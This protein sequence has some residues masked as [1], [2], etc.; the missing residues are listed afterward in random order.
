MRHCP[1][2]L[3]ISS[4]IFLLSVYQFFPATVLSQEPPENLDVAQLGE[5]IEKHLDH[6]CLKNGKYGIQIF[7]LDKRETVYQYQSNQLFI[8]ASNLKLITT[9]VALKHLG[10]DYRFTTG[11][12]T[13]GK[14]EADI[15]HGDLYIKGSGDPKLVTEQM[16]LL[17][18]KLKNLP[19]RKVEGGIIAD[20]SFFDSVR[21]LKTWKKNPGPEAYNAPL[22]ALSFNFNTVKVS[23]M[24]GPDP[25]AKPIVVIDPDTDYIR[26]TNQATTLPAGKRNRLIVNRLSR[27]GFNE[28]VL[29]GSIRHNAP[30]AEYFLNITDP[31]FY[32]AKVLK[33]FLTKAGVQ[34]TGGIKTGKLPENAQLLIEH[35]SEPLSLALRGLNKFSNNFVAEQVVKTLAAEK[36]GPPGT[37]ENGM[38]VIDSYMR[39]LGYLPEEYT[40]VDGSGLSR[41]NRL[42]PDHLVGV[43]KDVYHDSSIYPE[44]I[45]S[46]AVMGLDGSAKNRMNGHS[47][48]QGIRVKTGT[49]DAVSA[50]SGYFQSQGG[51]RFA[52]SIL[53]NDLKCS[54]RVALSI[55]DK[56]LL[57][58][59]NFERHLN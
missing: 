31:T 55:Q 20:D 57:E 47:G 19:L 5:R 1:C 38:R 45:A 29:T 53:M 23:A 21:R 13:T 56:I 46:L 43:L 3:A 10:P 12:Y 35:E 8:P 9:T 33:H 40:L 2:K 58:G 26:V 42:S 17:V 11:L 32:T 52:F 14:V 24:P 18:N 50:I 48:A 6:P 59:L 37:T 44:L 4:V 7:S 15:L 22:S 49:L 41:Q 16:W 54:N 28:I 25:G 39:T 27:D 34:V 36:F 51:E 30:R